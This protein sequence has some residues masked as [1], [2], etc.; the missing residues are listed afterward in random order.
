MSVKILLADDE[1]NSRSGLASLL[2]GMGYSTEEAGDGEEALDKARASLPSV[3]ITDLVMPKM[4]GLGL[5]RA[6]QEELPFATVI[7]LSGQGSVDAAVAAMKEGAYDF[8]TKPVDIPRLKALVPKAAERAEAIREVALLRKRVKQVWGV[9]KLVG[10]VH[11]P[12]LFD[13]VPVAHDHRRHDRPGLICE[14]SP[15]AYEHSH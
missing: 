1:A 7:L 15:S 4:D 8:L 2:S 9:G 13:G 12:K 5:L 11:D 6:L 3:V 14:P 10:K